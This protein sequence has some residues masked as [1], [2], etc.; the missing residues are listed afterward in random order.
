MKSRQPLPVKGSILLS[1]PFLNDSYFKRSVILL[2]ES[3]EKGSMGFILNKPVGYN[4]NELVN[5]FPE[6]DAPVY[7]GGPVESNSLYFIH[8]APDMLGFSFEI[9]NGI[10]YG[11]DY[12]KV[13]QN[14]A[15]GL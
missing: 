12:E 5:D 15:L 14:A 13:R 4:I 6:F 3:N 1:E 11:G 9:E 2:A 7:F 10:F 8:T